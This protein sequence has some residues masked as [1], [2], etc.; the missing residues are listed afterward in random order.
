[1]VEDG[2]KQ[3]RCPSVV[4]EEDTLADSPERSGPELVGTGLTLDDVVREFC[5]HVVQH[6]VRKQFDRPVLQNRAEHDRRRLHLW[7]MAQS[8]SNALKDNSS[9]LGALARIW[10]WRRSVGEAH[11]E[12]EL[13]PIGQDVERIAKSFVLGII[14]LRADGVIRFRLLR[15]LAAGIL[16]LGGRK[17]FVGNPHLYVVCLTREDG[18]RFVLGLPPEARDGAVVAAAIGMAFDAELGA[19]L[20]GRLVLRQNFAVLDGLNQTKPQH[21]QRDAE[22]QITRFELRVEIGL[23]E[24]AVG[25]RWIVRTSA[26]RPELMHT[27]VSR[28]V[29]VELESNFSNGAELFLK[30]G[31]YVLP[32]E[33]MGNQ[34]ELRILRRLRNRLARIGNDEPARSTKDGVGMTDEALISVMP[35]AQPVGIGASLG[36]HR[37]QLAGNRRTFQYVGAGVA[38]GFQLAGAQNPFFER[39]ALVVANRHARLRVRAY[40]RRMWNRNSSLL[41]PSPSVSEPPSHPRVFWSQGLSERPTGRDK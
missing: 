1:M 33:A 15:A 18:D 21:L 40:Q 36:K 20:G 34:P 28:A 17:S 4:Q 13:H 31:D 37:I 5:A 7:C 35:R 25:N 30:D 29:G 19:P 12:L 26:H 39:C 22:S 8:A 9:P 3:I 14:F 23:G 6:Q 32:S 38:S 27:A 10:V 41:Q 24:G 2:L 11:Q 16:F